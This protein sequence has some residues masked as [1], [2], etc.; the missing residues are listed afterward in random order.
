MNHFEMGHF[1]IDHLKNTSF[2]IEQFETASLPKLG[3]SKMGH[4]VKLFIR[5]RSLRNGSLWKLITSKSIIWKIGH[6][7]IEHPENRSF[8]KS[9]TSKN[10]SHRTRSP[11]KWVISENG[12]LRKIFRTDW[13]SK[14]SISKWPISRSTLTKWLLFKY[15]EYQKMQN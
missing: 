10:G 7:E 11:L 5:N 1:K 14:W 8:P 6:F 3:T 15:R 9:I 12:P 4:F 13:F 2:E